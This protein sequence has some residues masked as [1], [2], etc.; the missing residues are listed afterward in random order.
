MN[1]RSLTDASSYIFR[2]AP[3]RLSRSV[4]LR[5]NAPLARSVHASYR[6]WSRGCVYNGI[7]ILF[8]SLVYN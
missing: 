4:V 2:A 5:S 3:L 8:T 7:L 1:R 6:S